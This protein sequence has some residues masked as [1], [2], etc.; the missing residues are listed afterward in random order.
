MCGEQRLSISPSTP[1][2][3]SPPHV[4]GTGSLA[5]CRQT[6]KGITPACA[7]N[8]LLLLWLFRC[9]P[10]HPRMCGE[11]IHYFLLFLSSLGSPPHVRGTVNS[12]DESPYFP[13]I[14]PAC[15]GNRAE[16]IDTNLGSQDHP[17][18]CGEQFT[19]R[20]TMSPKPGSPPHVRGTAWRL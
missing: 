15:A 3:G 19:L 6:I 8:W 11:Q 7:G 14:T 13:G 5:P 17:R 4:R 2:R 9:T 10:D 1:T 20:T 12:T 16:M 18:M